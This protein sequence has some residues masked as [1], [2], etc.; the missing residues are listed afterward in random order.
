[1]QT[2]STKRN[3]VSGWAA[4]A[5]V[6]MTG[7]SLGYAR[8]STVRPALLGSGLQRPQAEA[9]SRAVE[10]PL[11]KLDKHKTIVTDEERKATMVCNLL[12]VL[13]GNQPAHPVLR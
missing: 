6:F 12:V 11:A 4:V 13:C 1:M 2:R 9:R 3:A 8:Y 10:M 5:E 7:L